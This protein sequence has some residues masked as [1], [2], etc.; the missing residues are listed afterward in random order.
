M[1]GI[2]Y[3][4]LVLGVCYLLLLAMEYNKVIQGQNWIPVTAK[5]EKSIKGIPITK[6]EPNKLNDITAFVN[7]SFIRY[8]YTIGAGHYDSEQ[9]L[10]PHLSGFDM[11]VGPL[12]DRIKAGST[13]EVRY[14]PRDPK[15]SRLGFDVFR[16]LENYGG[17]GLVF[18][19]AGL[20][21]FYLSKVSETTLSADYELSQPLEYFDKK[22]RNMR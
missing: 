20:I 14:N 16:P 11:M 17:S 9:E 21:M 22:R 1:R 2:S 13:I 18:I 6:F 8:N 12:K 15:D 10:G 5:V 3:F 19:V 4:C 7:W